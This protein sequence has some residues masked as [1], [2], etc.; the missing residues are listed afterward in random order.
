MCRFSGIKLLGSNFVTYRCT[1]RAQS[2]QHKSGNLLRPTKYKYLFDQTEQLWPSN[3]C[4]QALQSASIA[5]LVEIHSGSP[6]SNNSLVG[7]R[8]G[9]NTSAEAYI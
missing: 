7:P 4:R 2:L 1:I 6:C 8:T 3:V 5:G 9:L